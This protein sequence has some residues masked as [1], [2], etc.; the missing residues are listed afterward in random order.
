MLFKC[1]FFYIYFKCSFRITKF[2]NFIT[3]VFFWV[4]GLGVGELKLFFFGGGEGAKVVFFWGG[5]S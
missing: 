3:E 4:G 2:H 5:G 1:S